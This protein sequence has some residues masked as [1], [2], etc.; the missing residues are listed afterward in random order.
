MTALNIIIPIITF[1]CGG[2]LGFF[3]AAIMAAD[4]R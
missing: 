1:V 3:V 4:K 2:I